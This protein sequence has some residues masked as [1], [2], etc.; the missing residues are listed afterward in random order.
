MNTTKYTIKTNI[1]QYEP[2]GTPPP[3]K[4]SRGYV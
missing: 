3:A 4:L 1:P 2:S